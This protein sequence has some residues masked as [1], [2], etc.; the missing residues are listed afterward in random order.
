[1]IRIL[2]VFGLLATGLAAAAPPACPTTGVRSCQNWSP[3][4]DVGAAQCVYTKAVCEY[5]YPM[6]TNVTRQTQ[7]RF[8]DCSQ[9]DGTVCRETSRSF[10]QTCGC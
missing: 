7:E 5:D 9:V 6:F 3:Y 2:A 4:Y 10:V 1:M 8:R